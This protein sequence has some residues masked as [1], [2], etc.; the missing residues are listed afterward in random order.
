MLL[1]LRFSIFTLGLGAGTFVAALYGMNLKNF[2]EESDIGFTGISAWC[3]VFGVCVCAWGLTKLRRVQRVSMWGDHGVKKTRKKRWRDWGDRQELI[4]GPG[5]VERERAAVRAR[6]GL[7]QVI[8][9]DKALKQRAVV[10]EGGV[11]DAVPR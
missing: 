3:T 6:E 8:A 2:L 5:G 1:E 4:G 9:R 10:L 7:G 11:G